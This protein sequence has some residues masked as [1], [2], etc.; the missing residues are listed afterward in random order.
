MH[1]DLPATI[2]DWTPFNHRLRDRKNADPEYF[3][4]SLPGA[5]PLALH[6]SPY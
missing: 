4:G 2:R 5:Q 1:R 6:K 3:L